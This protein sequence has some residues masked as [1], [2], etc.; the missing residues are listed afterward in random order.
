[1]RSCIIDNMKIAIPEYK[2]PVMKK[3]MA[4]CDDID[5]LKAE[6]LDEALDQLN[7]GTADALVA[8]I[9]ITTRDMVLSCKNK[10][11]KTNK[12]F[13]SCFVMTKGDE[14]IIVAD[15]GVCKNP[16]AEM[17]KAIVLETYDT[18]K[19][20]L[21]EEPRIAMLS[22]STLGSGGADPSI[23][24]INEVIAAVMAENPAIK[25]DGEM[26][27]DV[28]VNPEVAA[29]KAPGSVVAGNANV[30]ICPDLNSGNILYKSMER[31]GGYTAA[32]P[33][34][35]GFKAAVSDL[36]RGSTADDVVLVFETLKKLTNSR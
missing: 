10:L 13:S 17:L 9:D 5:F 26:Q 6:T 19:A 7:A 21:S 20:V 24:K 25:I 16:N 2:N 27:L 12:Y 34:L 15:A 31:F 30:L 23:E 33:I 14:T 28:A 18:A 11:E 1:M 32:G 3:A 8:G 29:K 35:Q 22:F 36:S 4:A